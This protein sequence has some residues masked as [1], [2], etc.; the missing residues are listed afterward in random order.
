MRTCA[1][2]YRTGIRHIDV[3]HEGLFQLLGELQQMAKSNQSSD[4]LLNLFEVFLRD[5]R[6]HFSTEEQLLLE[7]DYPGYF[8]QRSDHTAM[9][10][11]FEQAKSRLGVLSPEAATALFEQHYDTLE[12]HCAGADLAYGEFL[13]GKGVR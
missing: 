1:G 13:S 2:K 5:V 9:L 10:Q 6:V 11:Y 12:K 7:N 8:K 3:Q 4:A